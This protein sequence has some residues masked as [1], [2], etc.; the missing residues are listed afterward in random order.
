MR[1]KTQQVRA[2]IQLGRE[3][4]ERTAA[5]DARPRSENFPAGRDTA[6]KA[7]K[8]LSRRV[9]IPFIKSVSTKAGDGFLTWPQV[10]KKWSTALLGICKSHVVNDQGLNIWVSTIIN[11]G[12]EPGGNLQ[13]TLEQHD[14]DDIDDAGDPARMDWP[15]FVKMF[16]EQ[17]FA[18]DL[19]PRRFEKALAAV[20][21]PPGAVTED[22]VTTFLAEF[23][24]RR[25]A[26]DKDEAKNTF[27][28]DTAG[29]EATRD[30]AA[31]QD[32]YDRCPEALQKVMNTFT[33]NKG[34]KG[35]RS[36]YELVIVD[37]KEAKDDDLLQVFEVPTAASQ[38]GDELDDPEEDFDDGYDDPFSEDFDD[39]YD[40][41]FEED[42]E[43]QTAVVAAEP[44]GGTTRDDDMMGVGEQE[45]D[46]DEAPAARREW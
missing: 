1:A 30:A 40:D 36:D 42:F 35:K 37:I 19:D 31:A 32:L 20:T 44:T 46:E 6:E 24:R 12:I 9:K 10:L 22:G 14:T 26:F 29:A 39:E 18:T 17:T 43:D 23:I 16:Q 5:A 33:H 2:E 13:A 8:G 21:F 4:A 34:K 27:M 15:E 41:F 38:A 25:R 28:G 7:Q 11:E 45:Q 3:V